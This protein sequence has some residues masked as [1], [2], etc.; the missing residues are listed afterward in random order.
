MAASPVLSKPGWLL[1][2]CSSDDS[3][4]PVAGV[5]VRERYNGKTCWPSDARADARGHDTGRLRGL[6]FL[7]WDSSNLAPTVLQGVLEKPIDV[8]AIEF[9]P[10]SGAALVCRRQ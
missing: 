4:E 3:G 5:V 7:F 2:R 8:S 10:A 9:H 1:Q 6:G